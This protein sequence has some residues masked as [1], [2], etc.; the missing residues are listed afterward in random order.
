L[1]RS[2]GKPSQ[3]KQDRDENEGGTGNERVHFNA[4]P[5]SAERSK[6]TL[7]R[8]LFGTIVTLDNPS[9][10]WI[11]GVFTSKMLT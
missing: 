9:R 4:F 6:G 2:A 5:G 11:I 10:R 1:Q 8:T 3:R 7:S